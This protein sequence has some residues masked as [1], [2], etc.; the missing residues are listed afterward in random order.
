LVVSNS[1]D[2]IH[3]R[4]GSHPLLALN[5]KEVPVTASPTLTKQ[6]WLKLVFSLLT[7]DQ[8]EVLAQRKRLELSLD[9]K[10]AGSFRALV[11]IQ[12]GAFGLSIFNASNGHSIQPGDSSVAE[13]PS[14]TATAR[15]AGPVA[16]LLPDQPGSV[17]IGIHGRKVSAVRPRKV[18]FVHPQHQT[19]Y[20]GFQHSLPLF[21]KRA[22]H[23]P[24]GLITVAALLPRDIELRL[25]DMN[26]QPLSDEEILWAEMV[27]T[28]GMT[29][30]GPSLLDLL[31]RCKR[32]DRPTVVGGPR[33]SGDPA[34]L[35]GKGTYLVLD[36]AEVTLPLFMADL[37]S[38]TPR[39]VYRAD[40]KPDVTKSPLPR[41]DLLDTKAYGVMDVQ[42]SRGC[43]FN[44]EFCDI[45]ALFG[46]V[47][48]AKTPEQTLL[49]FQTIHDLGYRGPLFLV[50]DNF[51]GNKKAVRKLLEAMVPWMQRHDYP[52]NVTTEASL[53]LAE[54]EDLLE[55]MRLAGFKRVFLGV[56]TPSLESLEETGK[57]QNMHGDMVEAVLRIIDHNIEVM[58]GFIVGFDHDQD[59][60][61]ERQIEFIGKACIPWAMTGVLA[62]ATS[63]QLW[64]RLEKEGRI[65]GYHTGDQFGRPNFVTKMD[66]DKLMDGYRHILETV[67]EPQAYFDR[68]WS[69]IERLDRTGLPNLHRRLASFR[70]IAAVT[71]IAIVV[72]GILSPYRRVWWRFMWRLISEHPSKYVVGLMNSIVGHHFIKYTA[73]ILASEGNH[74]ALR[75]PAADVLPRS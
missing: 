40:R 20:W 43:P 23:P 27:F 69:V 22:M 33:A 10:D 21:G 55:A 31:D 32:L 13:A 42:F 18:L 48:R 28:G 38:G 19:S 60:I 53:N 12:G 6:I 26:I 37:E 4:V 46:R 41:F 47:P 9:I 68:V 50:D 73:E 66:P 2:A 16:T 56:E 36:E 63:T 1:A 14:V 71:L 44:C 34:R 74:S 45:I 29:S 70:Q 58:A 67:Y 61:F 72:Q 24:L 57:L 25:V 3:L 75:P 7:S 30:Q 35:S 15:E 39:N 62:A 52:F 65:L 5:G 64:D 11:S 59:D 8:I 49:E 54:D 51:I 17:T